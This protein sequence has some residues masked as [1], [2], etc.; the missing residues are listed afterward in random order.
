MY[1]EEGLKKNVIEMS[2]EYIDEWKKKIYQKT[3]RIDLS[4]TGMKARKEKRKKW[5]KKVKIIMRS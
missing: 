4:G 2:Y 1:T 3:E 5:K